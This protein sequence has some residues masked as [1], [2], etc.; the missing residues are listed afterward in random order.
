V[1]FTVD[2]PGRVAFASAARSVTEIAPSVTLTVTR[3]AGVGAGVTVDFVTA[4]GTA[5]A[6]VNYDAQA[7][8]LTF[9]ASETS[10]SIVVPIRFTP[11]GEI[12]LSL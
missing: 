3:T 4:D 9:G 2:A 11:G 8:T 5:F 10:K 7:G 1:T 12:R 6:G